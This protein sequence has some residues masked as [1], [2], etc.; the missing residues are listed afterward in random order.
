MHATGPAN[1]SNPD[2]F[3]RSR[4]TL[5]LLGTSDESRGEAAILGREQARGSQGLQLVLYPAQ[6]TKGANEI[7]GGRTAK[8]N[9]T[10]ACLNGGK[11]SQGSCV[12]RIGQALALATQ[13]FVIALVLAG[14]AKIVGLGQI[15]PIRLAAGQFVLHEADQAFDV[16]VQKTSS[17]SHGYV[18]GSIWVVAV[19][20]V[21]VS[22]S[23]LWP[24]PRSTVDITDVDVNEKKLNLVKNM[25]FGSPYTGYR[26]REKFVCAQSVDSLEKAMSSKALRSI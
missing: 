2:D 25:I 5:I 23:I 6:L 24:S 14:L 7:F 21:E 20:V 12:G 9:D 17:S 22:R 10:A 11:H 16:S 13:L 18:G 1:W 8:F 19:V 3:F 26:N 15:F 4:H